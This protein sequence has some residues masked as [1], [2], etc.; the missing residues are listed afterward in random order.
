MMKRR[1]MTTM[2]LWLAVAAVSLSAVMVQSAVGAPTVKGDAAAWAEIVAALEK[3][4]TVSYRAKSAVGG[5][6]TEFS[7]PNSTHATVPGQIEAIWVGDAYRI[8]TGA[9]WECATPPTGGTPGL[10][11]PIWK[12]PGEVT[13]AR[14]QNLVIDGMPTRGYAFTRIGTSRGRTVTMNYKLYVGVQTGLPRRL[15]ISGGARETFDFYDYGAKITITLP[16][17]S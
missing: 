11:P 10:V 13:V 3:Q 9:K 4:Q 7:P 2:R 5:G 12:Q 17:C 8:R 16:P 15:E 6:I 14:S 1:L